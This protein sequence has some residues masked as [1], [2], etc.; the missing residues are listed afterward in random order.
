[1]RGREVLYEDEE[2][3]GLVAKDDSPISSMGFSKE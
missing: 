1:M 3:E 2:V